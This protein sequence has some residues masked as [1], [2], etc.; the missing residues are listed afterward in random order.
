[1]Y[2]QRV[3]AR[4]GAPIGKPQRLPEELAG[5]A[6][7]SLAD[8][9]WVDPALGFTGVGFVPARPP[10][11]EQAEAKRAQVRAAFGAAM[12]AGFPVPGHP[13]ERL[14]L[15]N[16][17]DRTNWLTLQG[18]CEKRI[19]Q[20]RGGDPCTL[21]V[22]SQANTMLRGMTFQRT[23]DLMDALLDWGAANMANKWAL[24]DAIS[25]ALEADDQAALDAV[26]PSSGWV[27]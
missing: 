10:L 15:R 8:L 22:R 11:G 24:D 16:E 19:R 26:D 3:N 18:R 5:L 25:D 14:Q 21:P 23:A 13:G 20:N 27:G 1:M 17:N 7:E 6:Q 12:L 2:Y 9:S 4:T